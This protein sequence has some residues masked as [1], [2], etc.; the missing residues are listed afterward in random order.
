M[1]KNLSDNAK[2]ILK[3]LQGFDGEDLTA[4]DLSTVLGLTV[5]SITGTFNSF[6][7]KDF[8][9]RETAIVELEDGS[10]EEVKFLKLTRAG[11]EIE[12]ED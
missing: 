7:R 10:T 12:V 4:H 8:A 9:Y 11:S 3:A 6:V 5:P 1:A 2:V